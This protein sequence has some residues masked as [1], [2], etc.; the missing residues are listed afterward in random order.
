M[1]AAKKKI[2]MLS[3]HPLSSS[4][5]GTQSRYLING[6]ID[7]K[8][9]SFRCFGGAMRH[10]NY[11]TVTVNPDFIIKPTNGFGDKNLLRQV[12][13]QEQPDAL[14]LFT[15][16]RFFTFV[17]EMSEE[18]HGVC[19]IAYNHLWDNLPVPEFNKVIYEECDLINCINYPTYEFVHNWFPEKTNYIP[20][21]VPKE[22][23]N[24]LSE[25]DAARWKH[26][27]LGPSRKDHFILTFVSRNARRKMPSDVIY[28]FKLFLDKLQSKYGHRNATLVMHTNPHD[29]EGPNL[30]HV[31]DVIGVRENV[32][33]SKENINFNEMNV[34]Y[35]ISD[36]VIN[37]SCAEGFGL[38]IL[39][40]KMAGKPV[41]SI[42]TGGLTR[43]VEDWQTGFQYGVGLDPE[44]KSMVGNQG[45]PYIWEDFVTHDSV[46]KAIMKVYEWGPE[47]RKEI[48]LLA[49]QHAHRDYDM[50]FLIKEWDRTLTDMFQNWRSRRQNWSKT[51][52]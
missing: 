51:E 47:K 14:L 42:K 1:L 15:D 29:Q 46:S 13:A 11:D 37:I 43:Q 35:N 38:G 41:I 39:E 7:T 34:L 32:V 24:S 20:H 31:N 9:Y 50:N 23:F 18:I 6:L 52:I 33:F 12:I 27:I 45:V 17:F 22:L 48:G 49:Q 36:A 25:T 3:D 2:L 19:P 40:A 21:A 26:Q 4:G 28:S 10:E 5:V 30:H 8:K 44:C 16:P